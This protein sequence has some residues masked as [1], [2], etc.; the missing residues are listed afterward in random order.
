MLFVTPGALLYAQLDV[1]VSFKPWKVPW[2]ID[3]PFRFKSR[4]LT[5]GTFQWL[6]IPNDYG[7]PARP[8]RRPALYFRASVP[9]RL[10]AY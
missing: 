5:D 1:F 2:R 7:Q 9:W 8:R 6:H 4:R 10:A 3:R